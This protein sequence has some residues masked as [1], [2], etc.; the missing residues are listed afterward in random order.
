MKLLR[1]EIEDFEVLTE[2]TNSGSKNYYIQGPFMQWG[3]PNR[4]EIGRAH[5]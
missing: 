3:I 4:N 2:S 5:V 1:E